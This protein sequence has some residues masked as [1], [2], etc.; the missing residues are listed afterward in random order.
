M[1]A[2]TVVVAL[3]SFASAVAPVRIVGAQAV[4]GRAVAP[5][6]SPVIG[7]IV[8]LVDEHGTPVARALADEQGRFAMRAPSAGR[9]RLQ[10]LRLGFRPTTD[11]LVDLASGAELQRTVVLTGVPVHLDAVHI[12]AEQQCDATE[13]RGSQAFDVWQEARKAL[14]SSQLTRLTRAYTMDVDLFVVRG[15]A[16]APGQPRTRRSTVRAESLRPFYTLPAERLA[17][18]GYIVHGT[19]GDTY[20]AP[21]EAVLLSESFVTSRCLRLLPDSGDTALV[22]PGFNAARNRR[23][24]D[25]AGVMLLDRATSELRRIDFSFVILPP[26][27]QIG[28]PRG[29]LLFRRLFEG[30]WIIER[31]ALHLPFVERRVT[32]VP[33]PLAPPTRGIP[34]ATPPAG[35]Q[36]VRNRPG[37]EATGGAV[38]RVNFFDSVLWAPPADSARLPR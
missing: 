29:E 38:L 14:L 24:P 11:S 5:D 33:P 2:S 6:S 26:A 10:L 1:R 13:Q 7:A 19:T 18:D 12:T 8:T 25:I 36:V 37:T 4:H 16:D 3:L 15:Y 34:S 17:E 20:Y 31:W 21:D 9:Y 27:E 32:L 35:S 30:S 28:N 22:R 23:R